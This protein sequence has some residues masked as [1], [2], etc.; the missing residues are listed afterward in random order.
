MHAASH[1]PNS[2]TNTAVASASGS[3]STAGHIA[4]A[5]ADGCVGT[6]AAAAVAA[7]AGSSLYQA[8]AS[9]DNVSSQH[10]MHALADQ[11]TTTTHMHTR[12]DSGR[13]WWRLIKQAGKSCTAVG[14][15]KV[16]CSTDVYQPM[17]KLSRVELHAAL[18]SS[19]F[20][21]HLLDGT[22]PE[23]NSTCALPCLWHQTHT[24]T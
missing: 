19:A 16:A 22:K 13:R 23:H 8:A 15:M 10:T 18:C 12:G 5:A 6:T 3:A 24:C 21:V 4:T 7:A 2:T 14:V 20:A 1:D 11:P 9:N 17:H